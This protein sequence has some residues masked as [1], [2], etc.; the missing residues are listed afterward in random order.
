MAGNDIL[1]F[2]LNLHECEMTW[3]W[4]SAH[5]SNLIECGM[6]WKWNSAQFWNLHKFRMAW[7]YKFAWFSN[8]NVLKM[9]WNCSYAQFAN[10]NESRMTS[11]KIQRSL[12]WPENE[13]LS[14]CT[15]FTKISFSI[16]SNRTKNVFH[17]IFTYT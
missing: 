12:E 10:L 8:S 2:F 15:H 6:I 17:P 4:N 1:H 16:R 13:I 9:N 14:S 3:K 7:K 5:F 11:F